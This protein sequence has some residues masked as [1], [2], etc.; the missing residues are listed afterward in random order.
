MFN[1]FLILL[2]S[3]TLYLYLFAKDMP[4]RVLTENIENSI[5]YFTI[6]K[7]NHIPLL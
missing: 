4:K 6:S 3:S 2:K 1:A 5:I 7:F